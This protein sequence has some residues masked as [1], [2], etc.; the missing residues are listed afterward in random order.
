MSMKLTSMYDF[1]H[2]FR[3]GSQPQFLEIAPRLHEIMVLGSLFH[4]YEVL[5]HSPTTKDPSSWDPLK[6]LLA[7]LGVP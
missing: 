7:P 3:E 5:L 4:F 6:S 2:T 1:S